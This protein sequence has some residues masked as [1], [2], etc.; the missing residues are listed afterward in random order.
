MGL[1]LLVTACQLP[2][3]S[4]A[5]KS[6][7]AKSDKSVLVP[8]GSVTTDGEGAGDNTDGIASIPGPDPA[9]AEG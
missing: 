1:G 7:K 4:G 6:T 8:F 9:A 5:S 2:S 3:S